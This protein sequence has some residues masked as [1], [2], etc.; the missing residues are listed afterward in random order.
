M[1]GFLSALSG[2]PRA[3]ASDD[4]PGTE[5]APNRYPQSH[6]WLPLSSSPPTGIWSSEEWVRRTPNGWERVSLH[7]FLAHPAA[8]IASLVMMVRPGALI[9]GVI[10]R[11]A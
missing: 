6:S 11:R 1:A 7:M 10:G 3:G 4:G 5:A 9:A 2:L 8:I